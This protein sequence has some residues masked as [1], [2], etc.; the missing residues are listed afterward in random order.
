[1]F[2]RKKN[3]SKKFTTLNIIENYNSDTYFKIEKLF[4]VKTQLEKLS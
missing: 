4:F 2:N 1:M 3:I